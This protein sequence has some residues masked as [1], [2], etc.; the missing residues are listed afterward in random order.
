MN[1]WDHPLVRRI[2][3]SCVIGIAVAL[4]ISEGSY[5]LLNDGTRRD[6]QTIELI[7]PAGTAEQ[8]AAGK[9]VPSLPTN[10]TFVEG[11]VLLVKNQDVTDHQ[12]GPVWVPPDATGSLALG[13]V[14]RF[15]FGC[16]FQPGRYLGIDVRPAGSSLQS[17]LLALI[18]IGPPTIALIVVY[19]ILVVPL[20]PAS[21]TGTR[22]QSLPAPVVTLSETGAAVNDMIHHSPNGKTV[23]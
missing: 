21:A 2:A 16:S 14:N 12:L 8:V 15:R 7:I 22:P 18:L 13:E 20:K 19:G 11:D 10:M 3:I 23:L 1:F 17:R 9:S 5:Y 4:V 6:P